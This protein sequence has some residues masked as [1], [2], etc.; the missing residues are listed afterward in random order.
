M[1]MLLSFHRLIVTP[2]DIFRYITKENGIRIGNK[3]GFGLT[4]MD[5]NHLATHVS[6]P[7][8]WEPANWSLFTSL[9]KILKKEYLR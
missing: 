6:E 9:F 4:Q 7:N 8:D 2:V 1:E 5:L 3:M